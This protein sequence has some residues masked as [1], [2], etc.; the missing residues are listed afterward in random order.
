MIRQ[1]SSKKGKCFYSRAMSED[2]F[3]MRAS[4]YRGLCLVT[5]L[6]VE[7]ARLKKPED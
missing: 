5:H 7:R 1:D 6:P 2:R 3:P 4:E